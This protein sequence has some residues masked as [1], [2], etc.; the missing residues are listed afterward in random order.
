MLLGPSPA[1]ATNGHFWHL[2]YYLND[3]PDVHL[4][5]QFRP[6]NLGKSSL[7]ERRSD[8]MVGERRSARAATV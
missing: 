8:G 6:S 7:S 2:K 5:P 1:P 3:H 4:E